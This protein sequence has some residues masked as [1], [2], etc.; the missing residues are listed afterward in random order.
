LIGWAPAIGRLGLQNVVCLPE[1]QECNDYPCDT[2]SSREE[3]ES[4]LEF[5]GLNFELLEPDWNS[6]KGIWSPDVDAV[7]RRARWIRQY[8]YERPERTIVFVGHG[9]LI[10]RIIGSPTVKSK[11]HWQNAEVRIFEFNR[12]ITSDYLLHETMFVSAGF[13]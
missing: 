3:L 1:A 8:L 2:G 9:D 7:T 10:R 4:D 13:K 6:K 5:A 12:D 11:A